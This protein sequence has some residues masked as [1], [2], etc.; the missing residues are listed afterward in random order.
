MIQHRPSATSVRIGH[1]PSDVNGDL[2]SNTDDVYEL[3]ATVGG[4][5]QPR[6]LW[7]TDLDHSGRVT[8]ADVLNA[9]DLLNAGYMD[10]TLPELPLP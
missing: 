9:I 4:F 7:A 6:P 5:A 10:E 2:I 8:P 1:L 3:I